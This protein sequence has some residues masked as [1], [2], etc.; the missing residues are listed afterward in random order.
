VFPRSIENFCKKLPLPYICLNFFFLFESWHPLKFESTNIVIMIWAVYKLANLII[1]RY[2]TQTSVNLF[3]RWTSSASIK[4]LS[5]IPYMA[6]G[7]RIR[8]IPQSNSCLSGYAHFLCSQYSA[9]ISD[10]T[11][12]CKSNN[13][14]SIWTISKDCYDK[15]LLT[16]LLNIDTWKS[17]VVV[18]NRYGV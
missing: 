7:Y 17:Y 6:K 4:K 18:S 13:C 1:R 9:L 8:I 5:P 2:M 15:S 12:F 14:T 3:L 11:F 16:I 10:R